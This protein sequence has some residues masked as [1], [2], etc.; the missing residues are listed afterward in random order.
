M[1]APVLRPYQA[2]LVEALRNAY[3]HGRRAPLLALAT[4]GGKTLIFG[5]I[6]RTA[7]ARGRRVLIAVHRRELIRRSQALGKRGDRRTRA[8]AYG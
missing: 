5:E 4:G 2:D 3:R 7:H 1:S 6:T 8:V